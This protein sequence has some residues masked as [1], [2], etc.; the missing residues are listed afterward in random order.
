PSKNISSISARGQCARYPK[1]I[2]HESGGFLFCSTC[3]VPV[4]YSRKASCDKHLET[5]SHKRKA[6]ALQSKKGR[7]RKVQK[8]VSELFELTEA[9]RA[10]NVPLKTLDNVDL[11][12]YL[13]CNLK[14]VGIIPSLSH[15]QQFCLP[16]I[17]EN[18]VTEMKER[19]KT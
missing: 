12:D 3:N 19:L 15:L 1:Y 9:F 17:F 2:F 16:R 10:A 5:T 13:E 4:D 18:H 8:T 11:K 7:E 6:E 14:N